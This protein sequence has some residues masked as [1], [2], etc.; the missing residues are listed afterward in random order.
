MNN[1]KTIMAD[2]IN[3]ATFIT[4]DTDTDPRL[5]GGKK[6]LF[7]PITRKITLGANVMVFQ[8][9]STNGYKNMIQKR[10]KAEGKD[11][12]AFKI[13]PRQW[14]TRIDNTPF[15]E[16][17]G[18]MYLEVIFLSS[19]KTHYEVSGICTPSSSIEGIPAKKVEGTQGELNDKV[20]IR[21]F[22]VSSLRS[23]TINHKTLTDLTYE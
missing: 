19:G 23:I 7:K 16:H 11:P 2:N 18:E 13:S 5:L 9:K 3:G 15:V 6:N 21:T 8:N 10:L 1:L 12:E 14:G 4:I 17:K 22:K 20:I